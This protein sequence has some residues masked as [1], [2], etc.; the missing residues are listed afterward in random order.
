MHS[1]DADAGDAKWM[2]PSTGDNPGEA[3]SHNKP[4]MTREQLSDRAQKLIDQ[5]NQKRSHDSQVLA[6]YKEALLEK[7]ILL[8]NVCFDL[9]VLN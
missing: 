6:K 5:L 2:K 1:E 8:A 9:Y 4:Q 3:A 7:V